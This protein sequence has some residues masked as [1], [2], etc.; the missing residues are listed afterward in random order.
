MWIELVLKY[1]GDPNITCP[2]GLSEYH[3]D[4]PPLFNACS[5]SN[6]DS[7]KVLFKYGANINAIGSQGR[8]VVVWSAHQGF[9]V[10]TKWLLENGAD[11]SIEDDDGASVAE[12]ELHREFDPATEPNE[13]AAHEWI[14]K[15]L[16]D[17]GVDMKAAE[18]KSRKLYEANFRP[19]ESAK[20]KNLSR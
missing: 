13:Y 14:L 7:V 6:L 9:P 12:S 2:E 17:K 15:F 3:C 5:V 20:S 11:Y 8:S 10:V 18:E 19:R 1:G 16:A 4:D